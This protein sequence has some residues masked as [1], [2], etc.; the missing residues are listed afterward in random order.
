MNELVPSYTA[1]T[2]AS[3]SPSSWGGGFGKRNSSPQ[4]GDP[5]QQNGG[6]QRQEPRQSEGGDSE[7]APEGKVGI[8][9]FFP[10]PHSCP[11]KH[12]PHSSSLQHLFTDHHDSSTILILTRSPL[13]LQ[14]VHPSPIY[15]PT[16][17]S[18]G[19]QPEVLS[20][21]L[22]AVHTL[23]ISHTPPLHTPSISTLV[24]FVLSPLL[25]MFP[26]PPQE[27][28]ICFEEKC[29]PSPWLGFLAPS[30]HPRTSLC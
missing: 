24:T 21:E 23:G 1:Y 22:E 26:L 12:S 13:T 29:S 30:G 4:H 3:H 9:S 11:V 27:S 20:P 10:A 19:S 28:L 8:S 15:N 16:V 7:E 25:G 18:H 14:S 5:G 17:A 2:V 6:R